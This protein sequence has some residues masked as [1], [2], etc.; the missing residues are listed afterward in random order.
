MIHSIFIH[1]QEKLDLVIQPS[2]D[3]TYQTFMV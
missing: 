1:L 3:F 2:I